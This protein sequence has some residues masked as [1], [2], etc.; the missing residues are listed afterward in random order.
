MLPTLSREAYIDAKATIS[1]RIVTNKPVF[2]VTIAGTVVIDID[3]RTNDIHMAISITGAAVIT[4]DPAKTTAPTFNPTQIDM[5]TP[6]TSPP[7]SIGLLA[8]VDLAPRRH[9]V[10]RGVIQ[11]KRS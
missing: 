3:N 2:L 10:Q 9:V 4:E 6:P 7:R 8:S 5:A 1:G 11:I